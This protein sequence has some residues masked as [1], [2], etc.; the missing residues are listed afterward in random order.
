GNRC[1]REQILQDFIVNNRNKTGPQLEREFSNGA[2]LFLTRLT[3][4][5][6]LT[7]VDNDFRYLL[8]FKLA[9]QLQAIDIFVSASSG[10]RFLAEFLEVGGVLTVLEILGLSQIK[11]VGD[12]AEALR[13]LLHVANA[14][15]KFKEFICESYGVRAVADCLARSK[16]EVTQDYARNLLVQ[17]GQGNPKFLV[18]VYKSILSLLTSSVPSP[19]SQQMAGQAFRML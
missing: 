4:W 7:L 15:R 8:G 19:T 17:L 14:G 1:V 2:S 3:T 13:L 6:R 10:Y 16:S 5:L 18:Q 9:L 12:K 11:E